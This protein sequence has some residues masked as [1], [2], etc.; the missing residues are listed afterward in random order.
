[1]IE[2]KWKCDYCGSICIS[3]LEKDKIIK[4]NNCGASNHLEK[5][6][7]TIDN[8]LFFKLVG[9]EPFINIGIN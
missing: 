3:D 2:G 6:C 9:P 7:Y 1:M 5:I 8:E 4:C